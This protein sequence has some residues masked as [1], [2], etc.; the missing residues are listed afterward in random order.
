V[1]LADVNVLVYAF[2]RDTER[3]DE[4]RGWLRRALREESAFGYAEPVLSSLVRIVTHPRIFA[5]PSSVQ[6]A[7]GFCRVVRA[8]SNTV[9]VAPGDRHW[10]IFTELCRSTNAR[11]NLV[12]DAYLAALAIEHGVVWMTADRHFARFKGLRWRHPLDR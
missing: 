5:K 7:L 1:V 12:A 9:R 2:R 8:R 6:A 10:S 11:G 3:H 4:Y